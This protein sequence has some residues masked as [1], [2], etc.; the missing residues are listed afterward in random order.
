MKKGNS[1]RI[2]YFLFILYSELTVFTA[3][4][5][6]FLLMDKVTQTHADLISFCPMAAVI[7]RVI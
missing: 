6:K 3:Q 2:N 7:Y 5:R 1:K 4:R